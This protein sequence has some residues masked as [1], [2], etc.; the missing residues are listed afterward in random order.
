MGCRAQGGN[1]GVQSGSHRMKR[2]GHK[3][4]EVA[5]RFR[6]EESDHKVQS[7]RRP[8]ITGGNHGVQDTER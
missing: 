6:T 2:G 8:K 3:V 4:Q 5:M 7:T 1:H